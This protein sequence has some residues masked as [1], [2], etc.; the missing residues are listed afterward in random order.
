[1]L[2]SPKVEFG[3]DG[4][5]NFSSISN[6]EES[7]YRT[8]FNLGFYFDFLLKNPSWAIN[9]GVI[10][11]STMGANGLAVYSL[12]D[13]KLDNAFAGGY[14]NRKINYFN[15]PIM[16]KYKFQN[17]IYIKGGTQLGLLSKAYDEFKND[18]GGE[19]LEYKNKIRDQIHVI[20]AGLALGA[21]Y[22]LMKGNGM[23][24]GVQ[25]YYG[26]VPVMKGDSSPK[27]YNRSFYI[28][29][30]IPIG[31]GKAVK[32]AAEQKSSENDAQSIGK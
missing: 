20:D 27:Q 29:V 22:R 9:T 15:V 11:K 8:D 6:L 7:K 3:L 24:I 5:V 17:N 30:G 21:G 1:M 13:E 19:D 16:I 18:Y 14:V 23:N 31:K 4:G 26:L 10:V 2:N 12:N 25:Y 32:K 28:T